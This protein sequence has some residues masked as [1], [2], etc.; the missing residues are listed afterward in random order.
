MTPGV[1][2][3]LEAQQFFIPFAID[4]QQGN[5]K[6]ITSNNDTH[7]VTSYAVRYSI[8][9]EPRGGGANFVVW[10]DIITRIFAGK[11]STKERFSIE[12]LFSE[13]G[14]PD[15]VLVDTFP[16]ITPFG[17]P[18]KILLSYPEDRIVAEFEVEGIVDGEHVVGCFGEVGP[19]LWLWSKSGEIS[20]ERMIS[21]AIGDDSMQMRDLQNVTELNIDS[22]YQLVLHSFDDV[23]ITT[24]SAYW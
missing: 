17:L 18:F 7:W 15:R 24:P 20:G 14:K 19:Y 21:E 1:T 23:C 16:D 22:F 5:T 9:D 3:W 8:V 13:I 11:N 2:N 12:Y 4:L 6:Q 10:D